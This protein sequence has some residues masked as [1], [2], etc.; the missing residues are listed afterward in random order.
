MK[1]KT[2]PQLTNHIYRILQQICGDYEVTKINIPHES[3][4]NEQLRLIALAIEV[5][6]IDRIGAI[7][8]VFGIVTPLFS[9]SQDLYYKNN[10]FGRN[11]TAARWGR[12]LIRVL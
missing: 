8:M 2:C 7:N 5:V 9:S 12:W 3:S 11:Y 1:F 10:S 4:S 6:Q